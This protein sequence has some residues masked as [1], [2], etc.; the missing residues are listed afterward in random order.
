ML[1]L[2]G[3]SSTV[4]SLGGRNSGRPEITELAAGS[5]EPG[6]LTSVA[7]QSSPFPRRLASEAEHSRISN[8]S[9]RP[10]TLPSSPAEKL[11]YLTITNFLAVLSVLNEEQNEV[12][13]ILVQMEPRRNTE[14]DESSGRPVMSDEPNESSEKSELTEVKRSKRVWCA[15]EVFSNTT[16][17]NPSR[18]TSFP[19]PSAS[20]KSKRRSVYLYPTLVF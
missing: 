18:E 8:G 12:S 19:V 6:D 2:A 5:K 9:A 10:I 20:K 17:G 14:T 11:I 7:L 15:S 16:D 4:A 3:D 1:S 13:L